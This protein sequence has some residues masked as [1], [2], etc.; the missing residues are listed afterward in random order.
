[1]KHKIEKEQSTQFVTEKQGDGFITK[2]HL[3]VRA[4]NKP[5]KQTINESRRITGTY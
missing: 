5:I 4:Q 1:M 3:L 2:V